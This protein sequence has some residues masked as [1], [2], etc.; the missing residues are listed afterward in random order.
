MPAGLKVREWA[1]RV[2]GAENRMR[3]GP[4]VGGAWH[5]QQ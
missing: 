1:V 2:S 3:E 4:E 5:D